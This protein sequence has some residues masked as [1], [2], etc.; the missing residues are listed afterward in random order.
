MT[1]VVSIDLGASS[2]R[3]T[4]VDFDGRALRLDEVHR[5]VN[6]PVRLR[7][8]LYWNIHGIYAEM[9]K[10]IAKAASG[11]AFSTLGI[12][13]WGCDFA[14]LDA[15]G[16]MIETPVHYRDARTD[17]YESLYERIPKD[18]LYAVTGTQF[19]QI[20]T[21]NQLDAV[22]RM[23]PEHIDRARAFLMI[24]DLLNFFL[25]GEMLSEY[26]DATTTQLL[27]ARSRSWS[28]PLIGRIGLDADLF[29]EI[30]MPGHVCG[31]IRPALSEELRAGAADVICVA[32]H[33]TGSAVVSLPAPDDDVVF[34]SSGTWSLLGTELDE[35]LTDARAQSN[36][37]TN[38][39]GATGNIRFLKNIMGSWLIQESR[40]EWARDGTNY[41]F[42]EL[43]R[44]AAEAEAYRSFID[45]D[46]PSFI[47]DG[48]MPSRIAAYCRRTGQ[49]V[50]ETPGEIVRVIMDSLAFKYRS[51]IEEL[52]ECTGKRFKAIHMVGGGAKDEALCELTATATGLPVYAGPFEATALG[53]AAIQLIAAGE[54]SSV[55]EAREV[56]AYS[57]PVKAYDPE[58]NSDAAYEKYRRI[59]DRTANKD[60]ILA[61]GNLTIK[62]AS[63]I[64]Y[65]EGRSSEL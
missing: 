56:I 8:T 42:D 7:D 14:L 23:K 52:A 57:F 39:G 10:G 50:P 18:E 1:R 20:N 51:A 32:S 5:F 27:D 4:T 25:T 11:G 35:P 54:L 29:R 36:N 49:P 33:D 47:K 60:G 65:T 6:E 16:D 59:E 17:D 44:L 2:G 22:K 41:S 46:D 38:E 63:V 19:I 62:N 21:I 64:K 40:R 30:V 34:I 48:D 53:N 58:G 3:L 31:R 12:D 55:K 43:S 37:F 13:T 15:Y 26:T 9:T 28:A 61:S 24:P 45:V